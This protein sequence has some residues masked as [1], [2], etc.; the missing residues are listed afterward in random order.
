MELAE[1]DDNFQEKGGFSLYEESLKYH[2]T[3]QDPSLLKC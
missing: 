3:L 1:T 2:L